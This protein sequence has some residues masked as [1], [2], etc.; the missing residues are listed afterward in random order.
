MPAHCC[1]AL[2]FLVFPVISGICATTIAAN[3]SAQPIN[4]LTESVFP[5]ISQPPSAANTLSRLMESEATE[6]SAYFCPT[7]C[8]V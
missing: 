6:G 3:T 8:R 7:I 5:E 1:E 4:S 2:C